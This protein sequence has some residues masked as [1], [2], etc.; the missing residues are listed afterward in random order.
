MNAPAGPLYDSPAGAAELDGLLA[1]I[2]EA[3]E[4]LVAWNLTAFEAAVER[5]RT[6]CDGLALQSEWRRLP[7]TEATARKI[8]D[9]NRVY[10]RLLRHSIRWS[11]TIQS[12]HQAGGDPFPRRAALHFRG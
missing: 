12:I 11:H 8:Q 7:E 4:A 9:L 2:S 3:I 6:I 5:Q 1:A 10:D